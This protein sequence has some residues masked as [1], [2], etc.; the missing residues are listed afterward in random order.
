MII[1]IE[2]AVFQQ[3][4]SRLLQHVLQNHLLLD[5]TFV[6]PCFHK[7]VFEETRTQ[8]CEFISTQWRPQ[9]IFHCCSLLCASKC[10]HKQVLL[11][12]LL[13]RRH[14]EHACL[15]LSLSL[16]FKVQEIELPGTEI[17]ME[18]LMSLKECGRS[19]GVDALI[20]YQLI[21]INAHLTHLLLLVM[22]NN[23][24]APIQKNI[25]VL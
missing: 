15:S 3:S 12:S 8:A 20:Y 6:L 2:R 1:I 10:T 17:K 5:R 4:H 24:Q 9:A 25:D 16:N 11:S 23:A 21:R 22:G 18:Q 7:P 13:F 19:Y 14:W